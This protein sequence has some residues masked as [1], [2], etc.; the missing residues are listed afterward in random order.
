MPIMTLEGFR[1]SVHNTN[2]D[3]WSDCSHGQQA[4]G[5]N[6]SR[7]KGLDER[8][9]KW[10]RWQNSYS[11]VGVTANP[12]LNAED[13]QGIAS[14]WCTHGKWHR[15]FDYTEKKGKVGQVLGP[16]YLL[17]VLL[18]IQIQHF[19]NYRLVFPHN[20]ICA[21][22]SLIFFTYFPPTNTHLF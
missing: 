18:G 14:A 11:P 3:L 10:P 1:G 6:G 8:V 19:I 21:S 13:Q 7:V 5:R 22:Y 17:I 16:A 12:L 20:K 4:G 9:Q 2:A 15:A